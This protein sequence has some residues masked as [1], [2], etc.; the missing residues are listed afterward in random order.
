MN[1]P[2]DGWSE[3][4][5]FVLRELERLND[6]VEEISLT[7]GKINTEIALLKLKSGL[8]GAGAGI[9]TTAAVIG[10]AVVTKIIK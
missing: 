8:W 2:I 3:W 4:S 1:E 9:A 7:L 5:N 6:R 10:I